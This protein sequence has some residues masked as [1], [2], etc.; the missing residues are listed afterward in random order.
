MK[1]ISGVQ[2]VEVSLKSA[3]TTIELGEGNT[4]TLERLREIIRKNGFQPGPARV[5]AT[6]LLTNTAGQLRI[7]L[8][9]SKS[10]LTLAAAAG[11]GTALSDA[12]KLLAE[13]RS[14]VEVTGTVNDGQ[15]LGLV[16]IKSRL[17]R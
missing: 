5:T 2:T 13:G 14:Q 9:P 10:S 3:T 16:Q 7:D 6:G 15:A 8:A 1:N 4:L 12:R 11:G 17:E